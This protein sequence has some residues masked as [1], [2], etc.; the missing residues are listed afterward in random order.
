MGNTN[1]KDKSVTGASVEDGA[2]R[3]MAHDVKQRKIVVLGC[4]RVGKTAVTRQMTEDKFVPDY[5]PTVDQTHYKTI[6][7]RGEEY[8]LTL[9]DTA[10]QDDTSLFQPRY[11][12]ATDGYVIVYS[13]D[14]AYSFDI[15][16]MLYERIHEYVVDGVV[17]LVGNK[18]DLE[19]NRQVPTE[20]AGALAQEWKCPFLECSAKRKENIQKVF[21]T[22]LEEI[23]KREDTPTSAG[24]RPPSKPFWKNMF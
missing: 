8:L 15:A 13:I 16:Q 10:G 18:S 7:V 22:V 11:T 24:D 17:V 1:D 3:S 19:K 21:T 6:K 2:S 20:Q 5:Y 4:A 14:D 23:L 9:L 12:I